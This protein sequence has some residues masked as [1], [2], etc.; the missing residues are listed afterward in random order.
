MQTLDEMVT[1]LE[2]SWNKTDEARLADYREKCPVINGRADMHAFHEYI[3]P[4][5]AHERNV[6]FY[7]AYWYKE[8]NHKAAYKFVKNLEHRVMAITGPITDWSLSST[9]QSLNS[10]IVK[11]ANGTAKVSQIYVGGYNIIR[12]HIR[13]LVKA[14]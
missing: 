14:M 7:G 13:N 2:E 10:Y 8:E 3:R 5:T 9:E 1:M 6:C 11:G 4:L 12:L